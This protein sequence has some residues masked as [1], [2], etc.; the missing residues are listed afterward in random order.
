MTPL[1]VL[2]NKVFNMKGV[3]GVWMRLTDNWQMAKILTD[4]WQIA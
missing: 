3:K 4:K 2:A 1:R